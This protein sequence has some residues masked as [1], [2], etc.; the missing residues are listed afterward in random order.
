MNK[1]KTFIKEHRGLAVAT[2]F[3]L[4]VFV[5]GSVTSAVNVTHQREVDAESQAEQTTQDEEV[6]GAQ[7]GTEGVALS[8]SQ[9]AAIA[10]YDEET[11]EFIDTLCASIWSANG[12]RYTLRF[13]HDQYTETADG[14]STQHSYAI[15]RLEQGSDDA[16]NKTATLIVETDSGTLILNYANMTGTSS[17]GS[18]KVTSTLSSGSMFALKDT[19]YE[20]ADEVE[21]ITVKGLNSEVTQLFGG[22]ADELTTKL[23]QWCAVHYPTAT[24]ATWTGSALIDWDENLVST[25]FTLNGESTVNLSVVYHT[26]TGS[27]EFSY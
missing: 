14:E 6:N 16:G 24:E 13:S 8:D 21:A 4:V 19:T 10:D 17:D 12:G 27:Y 22:S 26:D 11:E 7:G 2:L 5:G 25:D 15:L 3:L 20:R 18:E 1:L 9:S 23:S